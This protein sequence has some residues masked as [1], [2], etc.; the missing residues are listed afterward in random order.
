MKAIF[1]S[2]AGPGDLC[3]Q[4]RGMGAMTDGSCL[5]FFTSFCV[6]ILTLTRIVANIWTALGACAALA[7]TAA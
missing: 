3:N 7:A 2:D 6:M 4:P 5:Q 1:E